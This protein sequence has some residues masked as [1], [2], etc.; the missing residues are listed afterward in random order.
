MK[1]LYSLSLLFCLVSIL[2]TGCASTTP[3]E[4][5]FSAATVTEIKSGMNKGEVTAIVGE[6][7]SRLVDN[8]GGEVWQY[9]KDAKEGKGVK[10]YENILSFGATAGMDAEYVDILTVTFKTNIVSKVTYQENVHGANM[11]Q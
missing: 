5:T 7:R 3:T 2:L 8:D 10:M 6:P 1:T 4:P 11:L 9:R